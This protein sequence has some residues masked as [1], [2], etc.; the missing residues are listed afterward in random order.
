LGDFGC[1]A[2]GVCVCV[3]VCVCV[4]GVCIWRGS[5]CGCG[6]VGVCGQSATRGGVERGAPISTPHPPPHPFASASNRIPNP[7]SFSPFSHP[8]NLIHPPPHTH[9]SSPPPAPPR[10]QKHAFPSMTAPRRRRSSRRRP[11]R[12]RRPSWRSRRWRGARGSG[13]RRRPTPGGGRGVGG[14]ETWC[15]RRSRSRRR[16]CR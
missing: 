5:G 4:L 7:C 15:G 8:P 12:P 14:G 16:L 1:A 3:C 10:S 11:R 2:R 13:A 9:A 6:C